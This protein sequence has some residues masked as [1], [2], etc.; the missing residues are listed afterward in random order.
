MSLYPERL[1]LLL[2]L[3]MGTTL[4]VFHSLGNLPLEIERLNRCVNEGAILLAVSLSIRAEM[5]SGPF[6]FQCL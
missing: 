5:L 2:D 3:G 4:A 1:C 6:A